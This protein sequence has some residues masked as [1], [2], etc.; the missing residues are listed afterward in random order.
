MF[1]SPAMPDL[2]RDPSHPGNNQSAEHMDGGNNKGSAE[3]GMREWKGSV[4]K[5]P[6]VWVDWMKHNPL[7]W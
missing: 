1:H 3:F 6:E 7:G 2:C 5:E 4:G